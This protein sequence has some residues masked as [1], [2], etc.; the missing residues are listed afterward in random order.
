[1]DRSIPEARECGTGHGLS[2]QPR[3]GE[4]V[5]EDGERVG[6]TFAVDSLAVTD[7]DPMA[8]KMWPK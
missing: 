1:M 4:G 3:R 8:T 6:E 7:N 5:S 2:P